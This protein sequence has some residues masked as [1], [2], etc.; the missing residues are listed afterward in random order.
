MH[1]ICKIAPIANTSSNTASSGLENKFSEP[2]AGSL[3]SLSL[4]SHT[5]NK[6]FFVSWRTAGLF[7][8][9]KIKL[10][11]QMTS[12]YCETKKK[13]LESRINNK[14]SQL[15]WLTTGRNVDCAVGDLKDRCFIFSLECVCVFVCV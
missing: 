6:S 11:C 7:F 10:A 8:R 2:H 14:V 4:S 15:K 5:S 12:L 13:K 3:I 9:S 1:H